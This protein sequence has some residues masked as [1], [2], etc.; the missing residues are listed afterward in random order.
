MNGTKRDELA[1]LVDR[2]NIDVVGLTETW[3]RTD[4]LDSEMEISGFKLFRKDRSAVNNKKGGGVALYVKSDFYSVDYEY[5]NCKN[6]ESLWC[7]I[8]VNQTN[9]IVVGVCYRSP[10]ADESE[11]NELFDCIKLACDFN[12]SVMIMGDFN[13]PD[14]NWTTLTPDK[15]G[16]KFLKLI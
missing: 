2:E 13:Y 8:Y 16:Y 5:L 7:K 9:Y 11:V 14:I 10:D 4:I 3:G 1:L 6:S 12:R 15:N